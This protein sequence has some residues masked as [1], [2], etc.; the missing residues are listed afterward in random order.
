MSLF[1]DIIAKATGEFESAIQGSE[2]PVES[3]VSAADQTQSTSWGSIFENAINGALKTITAPRPVQTATTGGTLMAPTVQ[4][5]FSPLMLIGIGA[6]ALLLL[7][8]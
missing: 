5:S 7:R 6:L 4:A 1:S 8:R 3:I 2:N